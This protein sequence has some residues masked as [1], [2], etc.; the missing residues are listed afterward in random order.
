ML[1]YHRVG[2]GSS[3]ELDVSVD[4]FRAQVDLLAGHDVVPLG[5]AVEAV[6]RGD[7]APRTALTFDD[8]Y[9]D[10]YDNAWP[11]LRERRLPFTIYLATAYVGGTMRWEGSTAREQGAPALSWGQLAEMA[12][13]G[14][15]TIGNHTHTHVRPERLD[16]DE[17]D[18]CT[19][20][21]QDHLAVTPEHFAYTW[22]VPVPA[23]EPALRHRFRSA[24]TGR[25][26]TNQGGVDLM[27]L[28]RIPV[29]RTD[30]IEFFAAK[31]T[32]RLAP[33]RAYAALVAG[34]K[35]V[36]VRG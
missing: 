18:R 24:A 20:Q 25:L 6:E 14:L 35:R 15:C 28:Q 2:G 19:Q 22:G 30:P 12:D 7:P 34:A 10:V 26:G 5:E 8:G 27:R 9:A 17:L 21:V 31:L 16:E 36:G 3:D 23:M 4:D 33:E 1:I 32:G 13:S 11:L 29:R